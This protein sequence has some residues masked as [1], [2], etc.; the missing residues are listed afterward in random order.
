M[1]AYIITTTRGLLRWDELLEKGSDSTFL[2]CMIMPQGK[3][4]KERIG[5]RE[6]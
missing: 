1:E 2:A 4:F 5:F 3:D 6:R